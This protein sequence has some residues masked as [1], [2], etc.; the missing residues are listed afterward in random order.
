[1]CY[2]ARCFF[3]RVFYSLEWK[4]FFLMNFWWLV[5]FRQWEYLWW[6][7]WDLEFLVGFF[8]KFFLYICSLSVLDREHKMQKDVKTK[9]VLIIL[10][11]WARCALAWSCTL[12]DQCWLVWIRERWQGLHRICPSSGW[13][14]FSL[15]SGERSTAHSWRKIKK[16][17]AV[18]MRYV[19]HGFAYNWN[20]KEHMN[21]DSAC[22]KMCELI[23][24]CL[25]NF[26]CLHS[27]SRTQ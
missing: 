24:L 19:R 6:G 23:Q 2:E 21:W 4:W 7:V 15:G 18:R 11:A 27:G 1:M 25:V 12:Q 8:G 3:R 22:T 10:A 9:L 14:P 26:S 13:Q 17:Q 20:V 16:R 5:S